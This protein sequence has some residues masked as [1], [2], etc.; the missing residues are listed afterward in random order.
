MILRVVE[1]RYERDNII[2]L[3]FN[4]GAEGFVDLAGELGGVVAPVEELEQGPGER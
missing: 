4:D 2:H 3:K 1:A